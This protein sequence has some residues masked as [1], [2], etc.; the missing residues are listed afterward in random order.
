VPLNKQIVPISFAGGVDTKTDRFQLS[1][2]KM[3]TLENATFVAPGRYTKRQGFTSLPRTVAGA[4]SGITDGQ[5]LAVYQ[6][7]LLAFDST[8]LYSYAEGAGVWTDK[9]AL[10]SIDVTRAPVA[11]ASRVQY[12]QDGATHSGGLQ[13][14][15]WQEY[16]SGTHYGAFYAVIDTASGQV[17]AGPTQISTNGANARVICV[18]NAFAI[19]YYN[20][21]TT[22]LYVGRLPVGNPT[23]TITFD[24]LT[25]SGTDVDCVNPAYPAYDVVLFDTRALGAQVYLAF[26][27]NDTGSGAGR[28]HGRCRHGRGRASDHRVRGPVL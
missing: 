5:A 13:C 16:A 27:N 14:Y 18:G 19:Y 17:V 2:G 10:Q 9:G 25:S 7:E 28:E 23:A 22:L 11:S 4:A 21:S 6:S 3:L 20:T 1:A 26:N 15:V 8:S 24:A 12:S